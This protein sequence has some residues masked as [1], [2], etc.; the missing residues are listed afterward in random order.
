MAVSRF[1]TRSHLDCRPLVQVMPNLLLCLLYQLL[2]M[3]DDQNATNRPAISYLGEDDSLAE[4]GR[5]HSQRRAMLLQV[6]EHRVNS[7]LLI[8]PHRHHARVVVE[9]DDRQ[10]LLIEVRHLGHE[11]KSVVQH[12]TPLSLNQS[13][14][15][16][17]SPFDSAI[18]P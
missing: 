4:S 9:R 6:V 12:L 13:L 2:T 16:S 10:Q 1:L 15:M 18:H 17:L 5:Q 14:W 11:V 3:C 7:L 8:W